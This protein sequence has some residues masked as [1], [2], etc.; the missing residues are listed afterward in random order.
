MGIGA[1]AKHNAEVPGPAHFM[2]GGTGHNC[3][4]GWNHNFVN[5]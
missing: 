2:G 1:F 3:M 4:A 5:I